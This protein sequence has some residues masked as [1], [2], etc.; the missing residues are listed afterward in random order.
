[1]NYRKTNMLYIHTSAT[2]CVNLF[3]SIVEISHMKLLQ[4]SYDVISCTRISVPVC[5][6]SIGSIGGIDRFF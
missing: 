4:F 3:I 1:M 6:D 2:N 5:V